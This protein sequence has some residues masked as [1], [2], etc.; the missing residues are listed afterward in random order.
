ME[1][2]IQF[3]DPV[4]ATNGEL[5]LFLDGLLGSNPAFQQFVL[6]NK[7][8]RSL[9]DT[10]GIS[11]S[12]PQQFTAYIEDA[13]SQNNKGQPISDQCILMMQPVNL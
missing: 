6:L 13:V 4:N 5:K 1:T 10:S 3:T 7:Q 8:G 12:L 9:A 11:G 2:A